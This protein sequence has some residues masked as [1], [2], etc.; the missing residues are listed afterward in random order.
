MRRQR[1]GI[2]SKQNNK[3]KTSEKELDKREVSNLPDI[4][5]KVMVIKLFTELGRKVDELSENF[6]RKYSKELIRTGSL[7]S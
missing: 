4:E 7:K 2:C 1:N 5:F 6:N 3:T